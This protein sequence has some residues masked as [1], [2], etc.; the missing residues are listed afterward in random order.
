MRLN[1]KTALV[2]GGGSGIG[3]AA[4]ALFAREGARVV[5][6]GRTASKLDSTVTAIRETGGEAL[7]VPGDAADPAHAERAVAACIER[8][9]S[10][11][12][13]FLNAGTYL[14]AD[15]ATTTAEQ[16]DDVFRNNA[17]AAFVM[18]AAVLRRMLVQKKGVILFTSSTIGLRP[19]P[20]VAAYCAAKAAVVSLARS[21]AIEYGHEGI[22][23]LCIAPGIVDTPILD[24]YLDPERRTA[25]LEE[26]SAAQPVARV[27]KPEDVARLALFLA[28]DEA[29]W[30]T[31]EVVS[32]DGGISQI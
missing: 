5:I 14:R 8:F 12:I 24:P 18:S 4:A 22:R 10:L 30:M 2:T 13:A 27:G 21:V 11:D 16:W 28:S 19:I 15:T 29:A 25:Q 9:G 6:T 32:V 23:S 20:G 7:S 1:N 31:G 17:R 26:V 3:A